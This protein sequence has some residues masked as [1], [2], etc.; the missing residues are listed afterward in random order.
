MKYA[1]RLSPGILALRAILGRGSRDG[2]A[3][4]VDV[5]DVYLRRLLVGMER[6]SV[7][8]CARIERETQGRVTRADLRPDIFGDL[9]MRNTA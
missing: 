6:P 2:F 5:S 4:K 9:N 7:D 8:L 3:R 1:D